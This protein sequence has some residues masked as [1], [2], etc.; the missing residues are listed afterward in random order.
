MKFSVL[1]GIGMVAALV[2]AGS[3]LALLEE[4]EEAAAF[5]SDAVG[6]TTAFV[7]EAKSDGEAKVFAVV[8]VAATAAQNVA[9]QGNA[10]AALA[11]QVA[12]GG[13][14]YAQY[15][16]YL[17]YAAAD[18]AADGAATCAFGFEPSQSGV[19]GFQA[20]AVMA[21]NSLAEL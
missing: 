17:F 13:W 6:D 14:G 3:S 11:G 15:T 16:A 9:G 1:T 20:C 18:G 21:A 7:I 19:L 5:A 12:D 8:N 10:A 4:A 2:A